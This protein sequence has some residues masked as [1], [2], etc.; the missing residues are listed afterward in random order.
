MYTQWS[1]ES[2]QPV[3]PAHN[4]NYKPSSAAY[5][6]SSSPH[7]MHLLPAEYDQEAAH[8]LPPME[9]DER[10]V[11]QV[12]RKSLGLGFRVWGFGG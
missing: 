5:S 8:E 12:R 4:Y 2:F 1:R 6:A 3:E 11:L 10:P 9:N 7:P